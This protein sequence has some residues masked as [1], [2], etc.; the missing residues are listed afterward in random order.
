[1]IGQRYRLKTPVL[2]ILNQDNTHIPITIPA[3]SIVEVV[4]GPING[5][6]VV[7]VSWEKTVVMMFT[8]DIR[9][10]GVPVAA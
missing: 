10:H 6:R 7:D 2:V 1:M 8:A 4:G 9:A 5:D 3:G